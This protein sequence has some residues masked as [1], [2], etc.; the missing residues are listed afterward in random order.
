M[1]GPTLGFLLGS[2]ALQTYVNPSVDPGYEEGDPRWIGA[3]WLGYPIIGLLI[4]IF[5]FPLVCF[6]QRLPKANTDAERQAEKKSLNPGKEKMNLANV[7][8][9][10][11]D[12]MMRLITNKM[13]MF[14]FFSNLFY[15]FAFMGFGTFMPKYMEYNFRIKGSIS[16]SS[17]AAVGT[18][19]KAAG[20]LLSGYLI[21]KFK[22]SAR[23][24]SG[25]NVFT[26]LLFFL[27]LLIFSQLGCP[28]YQIYGNVR[29]VTIIR[30][31][32]MMYNQVAF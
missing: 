26:G 13:F 19:S 17:G 7:T 4:I 2:A 30:E 18:V 10:F 32:N 8:S 21:S 20:L 14:N 24:L 15:V 5:A 16:S 1:L 27:A 28:T 9:G 22:P 3:W 6:P 23:F 29:F 31:S 25:Y 12:A 11:K